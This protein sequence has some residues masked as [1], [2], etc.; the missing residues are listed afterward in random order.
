MTEIKISQIIRTARRSVA[1]QINR[2]ANLIIRAPLHATED[3]ISHV[4]DQKRNWITKKIAQIS[5]DRQLFKPKAFITGES[6]LYLGNNYK[7]FV[8][9]NQ[10]IPLF[11]NW[12]FFLSSKCQHKAKSI[13]LRWYKEQARSK[14]TEL[15]NQ[16]AAKTGLKYNNLRI[17]SAETRWGSCSRKGNLNFCWRLVMAPLPVVDYVVAHEISHLEHPNHSK[18]FWNKVAELAPEYKQHRKWLRQ[19]DYLLAL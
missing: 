10:N 17:N 11:F 7:L 15:A 9:D 5:R 13:F 16:Y 18:K 1:L 6:F 12:G 19:N 3:Y 14:I 8:L 4:V 2:E